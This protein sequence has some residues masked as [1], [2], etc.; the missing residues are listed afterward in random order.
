MKFNLIKN[1]NNLKKD[2]KKALAD[3]TL[4]KNL[5]TFSYNIKNSYNKVY[6]GLNFNDM[7]MEINKIKEFN[8][9]S[10]LELFFKFK[11][12]V[13]KGGSFVY[14]AKD[15]AD[16]CKYITSICKSYSAEYVV[17]T[18]SMTA[19]EIQLNKYLE[20]NGVHPI[21]TDLGEWILQLANERP[22]HMVAPAIHKNRKQVAEL[23][24]QYTGENIDDN[25][26]ERMV[27]IA[28]KYLREYFFK[29]KVGITGANIAVAE[30]GTIAIFTNEGNAELTTTIPPV[31][32]V[33]LGYDKL[34]ED[35][36][37]AFKIARVLPKNAA[38]QIMATY[39]T[40]IKGRYPSL[41]NTTHYK[42]THYVFLDNG[43]LAL[44]NNSI[45]NE[46][47]K[48]IRCGSCANVCPVYGVLGGHVFGDI[49][50]G[51]IGLINTVLYGN[52]TKGE[53]LLKLCIGC[54]ACS[55]ICPAGIDIQKLISDLNIGL[56]EK[57]QANSVNKIIYSSILGHPDTF[58][59]LMKVGSIVQ[60]P[61]QKDNAYL[62]NKLKWLSS[63]KESTHILP[64]I[65]SKTFSELY[66]QY[67]K[68]NTKCHKKVFFYPGCAIE[69]FYPD[70]G[71]SLVKL[72]EKI[73]I[74]VDIPEKAVCC[75]LPAIHAGDANSAKKIILNNIK[76][77]KESENYDAFLTLCPTCGST[78]KEDFAH[79]LSN[80]INEFKKLSNTL[81]KVQS[82]SM[83]LDKN[84]IKLVLKNGIKVTYHLPCHQNRGMGF[85][86]ESILKEIFS[87]NFIPMKE[88]DSCCGFGGSFSVSYPNISD[89]ILDKKIENIVATQADIVLTDCP[90]C[91]MQIK[92]GIIK[93]GLNI[94]VMHLAEFFE[95][96]VN[97]TMN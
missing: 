87:D 22:S 10:R 42:E 55:A 26:I 51:P 49:Y 52:E 13:E 2:I 62:V 91:I 1:H 82:L 66:K 65:S 95:K 36:D 48:C 63:D 89:A 75:G 44:S 6:E 81:P 5:S 80:N 53:S 7:R 93:K 11:E 40:W 88:P 77:M 30:T 50:T 68:Y 28:R 29:A 17:K 9:E 18:K 94:K 19:E 47:L 59:T 14:Q 76:N 4:R 31:H 56:T 23:F 27:K 38:G 12:N 69:Y 24:H 86:A 35:F 96:S 73:G 43:R 90:G 61:I 33:L 85:S 79:Y 83:F 92:S 67:H 84:N 20:Q 32:V 72:L 37:Q 45:A 58:K 16:A 70:I 41:V 74:M 3:P 97:L 21:E 54:K 78:I 57:H 39:V 25:D 46:A 60:K 34:V 71:I 64:I 15:A 8:K